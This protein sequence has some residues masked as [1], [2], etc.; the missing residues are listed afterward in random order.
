MKNWTIS[1]TKKGAHVF[2]GKGVF[3]SWKYLLLEIEEHKHILEFNLLRVTNVQCTHVWWDTL[4][5]SGVSNL[6]FGNILEIA[7]VS[8]LF[9][10]AFR[11]RKVIIFL[12]SY[13]KVS[14][15]EPLL[16]HCATVTDPIK[17][18][19]SRT[20][21]RVWNNLKFY[22]RCVEPQYGWYSYSLLSSVDWKRC[23]GKRCFK[24]EKHRTSIF[25]LRWSSL[26]YFPLADML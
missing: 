16:N 10:I 25:K 18:L 3:F 14:R 23:F 1:S 2:I 24:N 22:T 7:K 12:R 19:N 13:I 9:P 21:N 26:T 20:P 8:Q 4:S 5:L 17:N 6:L 15:I 11:D